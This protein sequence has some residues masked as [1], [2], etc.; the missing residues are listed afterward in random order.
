MA[1][2]LTLN[3]TYQG[4]F[5]CFT[6][7]E[8]CSCPPHQ[9]W[10]MP[11]GEK[12]CSGCILPFERALKFDHY[13][14]AKWA[15]TVLRIEDFASIL[16]L[17]LLAGLLWK[18]TAMQTE[19]ERIAGLEP[20][21]ME[22]QVRGE[23]YQYCPT[24]KA[25]IALEDGC[26]H[27]ACDCGENFCFFCGKVAEEHSGHWEAPNGCPQYGNAYL[28]QPTRYLPLPPAEER[29]LSCTT[30][31]TDSI[32]GDNDNHAIGAWA[33][34]VAMQN[35][36]PALRYLMQ[37]F[38]RTAMSDDVHAGW[39]HPEHSELVVS[40]MMDW[41]REYGVTREEWAAL[42]AE[43]AQRWLTNFGS[44]RWPEYFIGFN[45]R[46]GPRLCM[47]FELSLSLHR[48]FIPARDGETYRPRHNNDIFS[49][50]GL[51]RQPVSG[52]FSFSLDDGRHEAANWILTSLN[53]NTTD[54][55]GPDS[56]AV[57]FCAPGGTPESHLIGAEI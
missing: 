51:L 1:A 6:C 45:P 40:A 43:R 34:N 14:P 35:S 12:V 8:V 38:V 28:P 44:G 48:N 47:F 36:T 39:P 11:D 3:D 31:R 16:E 19:V 2:P 9:P 52:L 27:V 7:C 26:N 10:Q 25:P 37:P 42:T 22:G 13:W 23:D 54:W 33:W 56:Y 53:S 5:E 57:L 29:D 4:D 24:C 18:R 20:S 15:G 55:S 46:C 50:E 17:E 30:W 41:T 21:G 49:H 32:R